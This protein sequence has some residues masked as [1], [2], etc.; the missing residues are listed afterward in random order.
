MKFADGNFKAHPLCKSYGI[1][2]IITYG[3]IKSGFISAKLL[4]ISVVE[5][6]SVFD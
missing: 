1:S 2:F 4:Y 5:R 3:F 6:V